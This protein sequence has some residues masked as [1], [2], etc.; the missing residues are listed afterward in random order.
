[1]IDRELD[2]LCYC[3][4]PGCV[5]GVTAYPALAAQ[6]KKALDSGVFSTLTAYSDTQQIT[7][8][9]IRRALDAGDRMCMHFV[10]EAAV[11][12]GVAIANAVNLLNPELIVLYG[13]MLELGE[14]FLQ[15]LQTSI[16]ENSIALANDF[17]IRTS[18]SMETILPL[19]AVA[20]L[21]TAYLKM[22]DYKWVYQLHPGI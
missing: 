22:D 13:F 11:R 21:F 12:L 3:G 16:Q 5:E 6:I 10:K 20:E 2:K 18:S 1:M 19:G 17:S 9:N 7:V 14:Y 8:Q 4:K 15:H